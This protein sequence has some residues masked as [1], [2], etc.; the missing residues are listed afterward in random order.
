MHSPDRGDVLTTAR[1]CTHQGVLCLGPKFL[2]SIGLCVTVCLS[3]CACVCV[4]FMYHVCGY[5]PFSLHLVSCPKSN[6]QCQACLCLMG[7][8][9]WNCTA[10]HCTAPHCT[11]L[12]CTALHCTVLHCTALHEYVPISVVTVQSIIRQDLG[13]FTRAVQC[14]TVQCSAVQCIQT[15]D[16]RVLTSHHYGVTRS[17]GRELILLAG[18]IYL[19]LVGLP[20][21]AL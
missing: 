20:A 14:S 7:F 19:Q 18:T 17:K 21:S 16:R 12:H 5:V 13:A 11:A 6:K 8:V 3:G 10:L 1:R 9:L 15:A 2:R 4:P